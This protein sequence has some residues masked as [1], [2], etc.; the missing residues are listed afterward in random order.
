LRL[1]GGSASAAIPAIAVTGV[2]QG[3]SSSVMTLTEDRASWSALVAAAQRGDADAW[4]PLIDRFED[5]AVA[6]A[7]G[8]GG[9]LDD[10]EDI[11]QEAFALAFRHVGSLEDPNAFPAWL[12]RLVRTA[13]SRRTRR[14]RPHTVPLDTV[15]LIDAGSGPEDLAVA[16]SEAAQVRAAVECLPEGERCV[17]ALHHLAGLPYEEVA[18]FLGISVSAA[19]KRGWSARARLKELLP[20]VTDALA[21]ARPSGT[22]RFRDTIL[23]FHAILT[24]D[25]AALARLLQHHP[26]L[27]TATEDW[28]PAE[29]FETRLGFAVRGS[30]L[31]R[32]AGTGDVRL[33]RLLVEAGAPVADLCPC[34]DHES[35][36]ITA[37][38]IGAGDVVDYLLDQ[39]AP[40]DS[41]SF[42]GESTAL[43]VAVHRGHHDLVR[44]LLAA[45]ADPDATDA[46]GR[47]A[48]D[49]SALKQERRQETPDGDVLWTRLRA[50]D[51]FAPLRR[52]ALVHLPPAYG[53]GAVRAQFGIVDALAPAEW[54]M[55]GFEHGPFEPGE[56]EKDA[57]ES[58]T[59]ARIA[60]VPPGHPM[61][62]RRRFAASLEQLAAAPGR[63]VVTCIPAPG[64]EHDITL[65]LPG[66][67]ADPSVLVTFV[68][69]VYSPDEPIIP[70]VLPE[71]FDARITFNRPRANARLHPAIQPHRTTARHY[72]DQ[73]H[74]RL[75]AAAREV[76]ADYERLD[77][78][79]AL[80][81]PRTFDDPAWATK[82]QA[83]VR[84]LAHSFRPF[85]LRTAE[86]AA[87]TPITE[88]LDTVETLLHG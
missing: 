21:A 75:A 60:L 85:E 3:G 46:N 70:A 61:E 64:H 29:G 79:F 81:D 78:P 69:A 58:G 34:V 65:A 36:L 51:L 48:A 33:V 26:S 88:V 55:L 27:A 40:I 23:L 6:A 10:A 71:G 5:L 17:V 59:P 32:A 54:W 77:R 83:L 50:V 47:T 63:K 22:E 74:E 24:R 13:A 68:C 38:T 9:G 80:P 8:L 1:D 25:A 43:H 87:D 62:R 37:V 86:P 57:H 44:R 39:G 76:L 18:T 72:P 14:H 67:A 45:G 7:V 73:R 66:L 11:A 56:F 30:A 15:P 53:V 31:I 2:N 49:W 16:A 35:A 84:Y 82:A 4:P 52:G 19:K 41:R 42:D 12:L 28:T 20:M